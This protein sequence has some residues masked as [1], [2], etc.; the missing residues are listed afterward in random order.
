M[1]Q[2]I[3]II[4]TACLFAAA[5]LVIGAENAGEVQSSMIDRE[6]VSC[7]NVNVNDA[8]RS[9]PNDKSTVTTDQSGDKKAFERQE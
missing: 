9:E 2:L 3:K 1:R 7:C 5:G 4:F 6:L 8:A